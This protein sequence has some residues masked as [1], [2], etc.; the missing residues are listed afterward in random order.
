MQ[1]GESP[2][3]TCTLTSCSR[4]PLVSVVIPTYNQPEMLVEAVDSVLAQTYPNIELIV[5]DDGSTD[6]TAERLAEYVKNYGVRYVYQE[7]RRQ[8]AAR[9]PIL[10]T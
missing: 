8:A 1:S 3:S 5:V 6:D 7:N 9:N 4:S 2:A 10:S